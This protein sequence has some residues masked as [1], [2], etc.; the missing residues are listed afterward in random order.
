MFHHLKALLVHPPF[1]LLFYFYYNIIAITKSK[2]AKINK[3]LTF[4]LKYSI[5]FLSESRQLRGE[6]TERMPYIFVKAFFLERRKK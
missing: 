4:L 3:I 2:R 5:I 1:F 6:L